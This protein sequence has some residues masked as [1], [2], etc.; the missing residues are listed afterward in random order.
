MTELAPEFQSHIGNEVT[1]LCRCW[2]VEFSDGSKLGF[3]DHDRDLDVL[4]VTCERNSGMQGSVVQQELGLNVDSGEVSGALQSE[5]IRTED[6]QAGK[7]D[8]AKISS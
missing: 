5:K 3:S 6:I 4:G 8:N 7:Y 2:I 1:T